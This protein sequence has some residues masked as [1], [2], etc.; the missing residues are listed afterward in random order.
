[1]K[2]SR[3]FWM[4]TLRKRPIPYSPDVEWALKEEVSLSFPVIRRH[5]NKRTDTPSAKSLHISNPLMDLLF[6]ILIWIENSVKIPIP[7]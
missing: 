4:Q 6:Y 3:H 5:K 1:M 2:S 7:I